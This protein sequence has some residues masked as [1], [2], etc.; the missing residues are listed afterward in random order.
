MLATELDEGFL[1]GSNRAIMPRQDL[2]LVTEYD[3]EPLSGANFGAMES[4]FTSPIRNFATRGCPAPQQL[5]VVALG[6]WLRHRGFRVSVHDNVFTVPRARA[7]FLR[8]LARSPLAVGISTSLLM[9]LES[10][11]RLAGWIR[12]FAPGALL[13][14]GGASAERKRAVRRLGDVT[15]LGPGEKTLS[16]LLECLRRGTDWRS[17][18]NLCYFVNGQEMRTPSTITLEPDEIPAPDWDLLEIRPSLC[19][20]LEASKGCRYTCAF[21]SYE[22]RGHQRMRDISRVVSEVRRN[23]ERYGVRLFRF[24]DANL[25]SWPEQTEALCRALRKENLPLQWSCHARVDNFAR[26]PSLAETLYGAG[27]RWVFMGIESASDTILRAM[28]KGYRRTTILD[29]MR[30]VRNSGLRSHGNFIIGFPGETP[31]TIDETL[32]IIACAGLTFVGF[33]LLAVDTG[34]DARIAVNKE[35][36]GLRGSDT[37]WSHS[38]MDS[39]EAAYHLQRCVRTVEDGIGQTLVG[40]EWAAFYRLLGSGFSDDETLSYCRA[41][42]DFH[43]AR[44]AREA[45]QQARAAKILRGYVLRQHEF[46]ALNDWWSMPVEFHN[47][48]QRYGTRR[49]AEEMQPTELRLQLP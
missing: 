2:V 49:V 21:C 36:Y 39:Q 32:E 7:E 45:Q 16:S 38:S 30:H 25:T 26:H 48:R 19:Y 17:L 41:I 24:V 8:S 12:K 29:G 4:Y 47:E 40:D 1:A 9:S 34:S 27:C 6:T 33:F 5:G 15:V 10:I 13:I 20:S 28:R 3:E 44:R 37:S 43:R 18:D 22:G 11:S 35:A 46:W 31:S 23:Y 42:R 14:L